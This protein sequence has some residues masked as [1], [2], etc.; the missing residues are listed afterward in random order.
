MGNTPFSR[1]AERRTRR[2]DVFGPALVIVLVLVALFLFGAVDGLVA[3]PIAAAMAVGAAACL[4][5]AGPRYATPGMAIG[6]VGLVLW[7]ATGA[8]GPLEYALPSLLVLA[9]AGALWTVG[10]VAARL[11]GALE[12]AW[13]ALVWALVAYC[14][15]RFYVHVSAGLTQGPPAA[16]IAAAEGDSGMR[17]GLIRARADSAVFGLLTLIGSARV[18]QTIKLLRSEKASRAEMIDA[19]LSRGLSGVLLFGL[20][21]ACAAT[22]QSRSGLLIAIGAVT[23]HAFLEIT[24]Y[25]RNRHA[26]EL[27]EKLRYPTLLLATSL[28]AGGVGISWMFAND[29]WA[30]PIGAITAPSRLALVE[31]YWRAALDTP[32]LGHGLGS[33]GRIADT[34]HDLR[35]AFGMFAYHDGPPAL[36]GWLAETGVVGV[37]AAVAALGAMHWAIVRT[38][39]KGQRR[40]RGFMRLALAA[41]AF[42]LSDALIDSAISVPALLWLYALILGAA[43]GEQR[44][45]A[46]R[47]TASERELSPTAPFEADRRMRS[48]NADAM[49]SPGKDIADSGQ[50][51]STRRY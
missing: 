47:P 6:A 33:S 19:T 25:T 18:L 32:V 31:T 11:E 40:T 24:G 3:Q 7:G 13:K 48:S 39:F 2:R 17:G 30:T 12:Y 38:M 28:L 8:A 37:A 5:L 21:L 27:L 10:N 45:A 9:G 43:M 23:F 50:D 51:V 4:A 26:N 20:G 42:M 41:S 22:T 35:E 14:L 44:L 36:L 1:S 15:W 16:A 29:S 34:A 46:A 49:M